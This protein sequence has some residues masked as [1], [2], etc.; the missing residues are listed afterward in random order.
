MHKYGKGIGNAWHDPICGVS[1]RKVPV[2]RALVYII[3]LEY[4]WSDARAA[5]NFLKPKASRGTRVNKTE[6]LLSR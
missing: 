2:H 4:R 1:R 3:P 6:D 5:R